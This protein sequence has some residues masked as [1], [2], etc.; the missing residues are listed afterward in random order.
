MT[1]TTPALVGPP[2]PLDPE[3]GAVLATLPD[4][5]ALTADTI[6]D[7]RSGMA[8][9]V[10]AP[11]DEDLARGGAYTVEERTVPGPA[12]AP[13]IR[14]VVCRPATPGP[15]PVLFHTHGGGMIVGTARDGIVPVLDLAEP[16]GAAVVSV[17]YRLAPETPHPGPI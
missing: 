15:V 1:T 12:G 10:P 6:P 13:D 5:P 16:L 8:A 9:I 17:D 3:C 2:P 14:L 7:M 4:F 11:S